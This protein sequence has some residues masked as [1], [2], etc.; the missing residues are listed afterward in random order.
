MCNSGRCEKCRRRADLARG[1]VNAALTSP[2]APAGVDPKADAGAA[3]LPF[4]AVPW[5]VIAEMAIGHGEGAV[6]YDP[7]NWRESGG[8]CAQT[9][10]A[11][12]FRHL[13]ADMLGE[14]IDA[15]SG[16]PHIV[17]AMCSLAV[18]RDARIHGVAVED[19][20]PPSPAGFM[21]ALNDA[22]GVTRA[23]ASAER[24]A[25]AGRGWVQ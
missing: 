8:V 7:H 1:T 10:R 17:K 15:K 24:A 12:A 22:W 9:Y 18:L 16:L 6:K 19:G 5:A 20:P 3:R 14:E 4:G 25:M 13:V 2:P 21:D 11:A 23:L